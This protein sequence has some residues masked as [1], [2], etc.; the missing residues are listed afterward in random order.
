MQGI[1][2]KE[3]IKV[4]VQRLRS[5]SPP[6]QHDHDWKHQKSNLQR[7]SD[8]NANGKV[9]LIL[10]S[11]SDGRGVLG[12]VSDN[13]QEDQTNE[14]LRNGTT[15]GH[16]VDGAD[17]ELRTQ[18]DQDGGDGKGDEST[19]DGQRRRLFFLWLFVD[20]VLLV[21]TTTSSGGSRCCSDHCNALG[22]ELVC[23]Q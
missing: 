9:H 23:S 10:D 16:G 12:G 7:G 13:R 19:E 22:Y 3:T 18:G 11:D 6:V 20:K 14:L 4:Q 17:H 15:L 21:D 1:L 5:N 8:S 2:T